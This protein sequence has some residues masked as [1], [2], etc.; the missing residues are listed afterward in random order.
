MDL[1]YFWIGMNWKV[2]QK[3]FKALGTKTDI[4][5]VH[6]P[7]DKIKAGGIDYI[8]K[9][10]YDLEYIYLP[11]KSY[12]VALVY[13]TELAKD[14]GGEPIDYLGDEEL[15]VDDI[16]YVPYYNDPDTYHTLLQD[17]S[18]HNSP[19]AERIKDY[20]RKEMLLE[21]FKND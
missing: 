8:T 5:G 13:A 4:L 10:F 18:W 16:H 12:C 1:S 14:F 19:M 21:G 9:Q 6:I 20:Y 2:N 7:S 11:A 3:I 17:T 15:L